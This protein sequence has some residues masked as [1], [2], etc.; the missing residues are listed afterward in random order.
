MGNS[1]GLSKTPSNWLNNPNR[2]VEQVSWNHVQ[3]FLTRLNA[4]ES[5]NLPS[6]WSYVLPTEAQWEYACRA[7]TTTAYSWG[8]SISSS[9]ANYAFDGL[10]TGIQQTSDV[11]QY[12]PNPWGF[13]DMH[14]NVLEWVADWYG[15]YNSYAVTDPTGPALGSH[16]VFRGGSFGT[17]WSYVRSAKRY[18]STSIDRGDTL[19]FRLGFQSSK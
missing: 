16:R 8:N 1:D 10:G 19:G 12:S 11:G 14:G 17:F 18:N 5:S 15:P 13:Y 3:V 2:P 7:G 6:G 4:K 9:N